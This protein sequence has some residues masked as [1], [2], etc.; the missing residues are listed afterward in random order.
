MSPTFEEQSVIYLEAIASRKRNPAK[1]SSLATIRSLIRAATPTLGGM[2]LEDIRS[3]SLKTLAAALD[4]EGYSSNT[5]H[6]VLKTAKMIVASD[7]DE[8]G[9]SRHPRKWNTKFIDAPPV[10][11]KDVKPPTPEQIQDALAK[12]NPPMRQFVA[13][14]AATGLR[15]GEL[16]ALKVS[17]FDPEIGLLHISRTRSR[18][19][20]TATKTDAGKRDVDIVP[21]IVSILVDTLDGRTTGRLFDVTLDAVRW[22]YECLGMRSHS[23]RHFRYTLLQEHQ[24]H[25]AIHNYWIGH[26]M[27]GMVKYYGHIHENVELRQRI[28]REVGLGFTLPP[29]PRAATPAVIVEE[30]QPELATQVSA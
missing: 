13:T 29:I 20:E 19:G 6:S 3:G 26:S 28:A 1:P 22:A 17:D 5:I 14:Q 9:D 10:K 7:V 16:L 23:L 11:S 4:E 27:K 30:M 8:N 12:L 2:K 15:K 25:P 18:H 21:E 24:I